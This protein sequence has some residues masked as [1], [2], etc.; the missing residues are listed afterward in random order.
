ML[1]IDLECHLQA[2]DR[3]LAAV[4]GP[5]V[6][7]QTAKRTTSYEHIKMDLFCY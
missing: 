2:C 7:H 6:T 4:S 1:N 3:W 5:A